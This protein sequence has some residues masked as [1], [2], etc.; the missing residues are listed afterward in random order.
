MRIINQNCLFTAFVR[1][2]IMMD[3]L[4][5][6]NGL[7]NRLQM[8]WTAFIVR[9]GGNIDFYWKSVGKNVSSSSLVERVVSDSNQH[10]RHL[11]QW[12]QADSIEDFAFIIVYRE[13]RRYSWSSLNN[14]IAILKNIVWRVCL[15]LSHGSLL[16]V[17]PH[18][19]FIIQIGD[20][21]NLVCSWITVCQITD[22]SPCAARFVTLFNI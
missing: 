21:P 13:C 17:K 10:D 4:A 14:I 22:A 19:K 6:A 1:C 15:K 2:T 9:F 3:L 18:I 20:Q 16:A 12:I 11:I 5:G 7:N 8:L